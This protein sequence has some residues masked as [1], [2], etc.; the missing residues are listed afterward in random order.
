MARRRNDAGRKRG[1]KYIKELAGQDTRAVIAPRFPDVVWRC[2]GV[3]P[4]AQCA[5]LQI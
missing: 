5:L 1:P 3:W 4:R 2:C